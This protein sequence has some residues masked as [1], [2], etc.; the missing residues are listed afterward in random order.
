MNKLSHFLR[1][2]LPVILWALVIFAFSSYQ[3][4][5]ASE[6]N[7][8]DFAV[9]KMAHMTEYAVLTVLLYRGLFNSGVS[10]MNALIYSVVVAALYGA[11]DE[12]H[13]SFT[14]GREPHLRDVVF[15]TIGAGLAAFILWKLLPKAPAKLRK[16]GE[17]YQL[18]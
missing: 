7:W 12:F 3:T 5:T 10:K 14:P 16:L 11:S 17:N 9:K 4:G 13:Q 15:D 18:I 8:Q 1:F 2:F 6:I